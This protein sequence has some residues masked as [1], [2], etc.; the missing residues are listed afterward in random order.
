MTLAHEIVEEARPHPGGEGLTLRREREERLGRSA[1]GAAG[2]HGRPGSAGQK[3]PIWAIEMMA[4]A[5]RRSAR[6]PPFT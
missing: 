4:Q 1:G 6:I 3:G 5:A 2:W